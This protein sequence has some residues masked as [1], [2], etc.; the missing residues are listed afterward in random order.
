MNL[1]PSFLYGVFRKVFY[2]LK[3]KIKT[4]FYFFLNNYLK[5]K[6]SRFILFFQQNKYHKNNEMIHF[7]EESLEFD[8]SSK[9][10]YT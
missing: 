10:A 2:Y 6:H 9:T 8:H 1:D 5:K 3:K 7:L 4:R